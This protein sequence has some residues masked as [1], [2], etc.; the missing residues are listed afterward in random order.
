MAT[1]DA[2][3]GQ[4]GNVCAADRACLES[5]CA[6]GSALYGNAVDLTFLVGAPLRSASDG[7]VVA[8]MFESAFGIQLFTRNADGTPRS[9]AVRFGDTSTAHEVGGADVAYGGGIFGVT[10]IQYA[11]RDVEK[12]TVR[13]ARFDLDGQPVGS[14]VT[15]GAA[16]DGG[17]T[18]LVYHPGFG[19]VVAYASPTESVIHILGEDASAPADPLIIP[20]SS[21]IRAYVRALAISPGGVAGAIYQMKPVAEPYQT[22]F[23]RLPLDGSAAAASTA[24]ETTT[25]PVLYD[26]GHDATTWAAVSSGNG[27]RHDVVLRSGPELQ[28]K[29]FLLETTTY[30]VS[31]PELVAGSGEIA[32][33]WDDVAETSDRLRFQRFRVSST[34]PAET[35]PIDQLLHIDHAD[36]W[37]PTTPQTLTRVAGGYLPIGMTEIVGSTINRL[38]RATPI[39]PLECP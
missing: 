30:N 35:V 37:V 24:V 21:N 34:Q 31:P 6:C 11:S 14:E 33:L 39:A 12:Y 15:L 3:C 20:G 22:L 19:F 4:C 28:N 26:L 18:R 1:D 32:V 2:N 5:V 13:F 38:V 27:F 10:Y 36:G 7:A 25:N 29:R 16:G 23:H 8:V 17:G 9:D